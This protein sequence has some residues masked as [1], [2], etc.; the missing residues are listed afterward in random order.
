MVHFSF[1]WVRCHFLRIIRLMGFFGGWDMMLVGC[2]CVND[3][4]VT[5]DFHLICKTFQK[6]NLYNWKSIHPEFIEI[7]VSCLSWCGRFLS[8]ELVVNQMN[9][10]LV[11]SSVAHW[12]SSQMV[13]VRKS[14]SLFLFSFKP[15]RK[16]LEIY[17]K[18]LSKQKCSQF[19]VTSHHANWTWVWMRWRRIDSSRWKMFN[20]QLTERE[21]FVGQKWI[22]FRGNLFRMLIGYSMTSKAIMLMIKYLAILNISSRKTFSSFEIDLETF[23]NKL[24]LRN[25]DALM[26][27]FKAMYI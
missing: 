2:R 21:W 4:D 5:G 20:S 10:F 26:F 1:T 14:F 23:C 11:Q 8:E 24:I 3:G 6:H 19:L 15:E 13:L 27:N 22:N 9:R 7:R 12:K 25:V 18:L 16:W 17:F